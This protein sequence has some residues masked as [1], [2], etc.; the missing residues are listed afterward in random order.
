MAPQA[1]RHCYLSYDVRGIQ[2]FIFS[3]PKLK[4]VV[5]ASALID[6]FDRVDVRSIVESMG[7]RAALVFTGGGRGTVRCQDRA[8]ANELK[9]AIVAR[10]HKL[11]L[12]LRIGT[13]EKIDD[14]MRGADELYPYVPE[15]LEGEP[16]RAS[17]L[18]PI[19]FEQSRGFASDRAPKG[20][21]PVVWLRRQRALES[22]GNR[23]RD[24]L[25][26]RIVEELGRRLPEDLAGEQLAFFTH[27]HDDEEMEP[28]HR[29]SGE[30]AR[31]A[32]GDRN[33]W[34]IVAMDGN[35]MGA[36]FRAFERSQADEVETWLAAMSSALYRC[37]WNSFLES[38]G[39]V[40]QQ[41]W[42]EEGRANRDAITNRVT[43]EILLP[44]RPLIVGGDDILCLAHCSY[45]MPLAVEVARQFAQN[46]ASC[47]E[48]DR[49]WLATGG[50]LTISGGIAY[51]SVSLPLYSS[52][53]YAE[54]LLG[55][56]KGAF[57]KQRS[58]GEPTPAALDWEHITE[59]MLDTPAARRNRDLRFLD[60]ECGDAEIILTQR[61]YAI[62]TEL[63]E[64]SGLQR[65]IED[66]AIPRSLLAEVLVEFTRPWSHR[67]RWLASAR[68]H[69]PRLDKWLREWWLEDGSWDLGS[70]WRWER[71]PASG[72][73]GGSRSTSFMDVVLL[74]EEGYRMQSPTVV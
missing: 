31:H 71:R 46:S 59:S 70:T 27:V 55:S 10:A 63:E 56:A 19:P 53:P 6:E 66:A 58:S 29:A 25:G 49:L 11:G 39:K 52:I 68:K 36:Q 18:W 21:H 69:H 9:Q 51:T 42:E 28:E 8:T 47:K 26:A 15:S 17:G 22:G 14:A 12:D 20:I 23:K 3:V 73:T 44:F 16:C 43:G 7:D 40:I 38:L 72:G 57:R 5:G 24:A 60:P 50:R 62:D 35:D 1:T 61:P 37:T 54:S 74:L 41:W 33:R 13:D 45:A 30:A 4:Y 64:L 34:A 48:A 32:L 65:E 67:L 2:Q